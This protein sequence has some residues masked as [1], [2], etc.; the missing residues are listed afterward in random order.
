MTTSRIK[1]DN[2][3][4]LLMCFGAACVAAISLS[5][6]WALMGRPQ[7][8]AQTRVMVQRENVY[9]DEVAQER[10]IRDGAT[11]RYTACLD[12]G[13]SAGRCSAYLYAQGYGA[14]GGGAYGYGLESMAQG[15]ARDILIARGE[16]Q[17]GLQNRAI[18]GLWGDLETERT[19]RVEGDLVLQGLVD[20][21]RGRADEAYGRAD[22]AYG[23]ASDAHG[24]LDKA[25]RA[26]S[27]IDERSRARDGD[28]HGRLQALEVRRAEDEDADDKES[29]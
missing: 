6:C 7:D 25:G 27:T 17:D 3:F 1:S 9:A 13:H 19:E 12:E 28:L 2:V 23:R 14:Y 18:R 26:V 4:G 20:D 16:Q 5:G 11:E 8:L 10:E 21:A 22:A 29:K 24:R 15:A